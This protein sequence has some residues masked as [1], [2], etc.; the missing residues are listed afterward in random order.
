MVETRLLRSFV[1]VAE[2]L[3]FGRAARRLHIA[4]PALTRQIQQL[5]ERLQATLLNRNQRIV[6]LTPA[7][8][9]FLERSYRILADLEQ[10]AK[11]VRRVEA[12]QEGRLSVGFIHSSTYGVTPL[13]LRRFRL[14]FPRV[15]LELFEMTIQEQLAALRDGQIDVGILRPPISDPSLRARP[16][17][18]ERFV[19]ALPHDHRLA[20]TDRLH[21]R[22][23]SEDGF[24]LFTQRKSPL[25][26]ARIIGMCEKAGFVPRVEQYATQIHTMIGLVSAG[27]GAAIVPEVA[28]SLNIPGV[29]YVEIADTPP[30]V[31]VC[32]GWRATDTSPILAAFCDH[33]ETSA[34]L[35]AETAGG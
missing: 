30:T 2:E 4:Q 20:S 33:A 16:L 18:E 27:M 6:T 35:A 12:G 15:D 25:F 32:L 28:R 31:Q 8:R 24:I 3:H 19:V 14:A 5:E 9:M 21:L 22:D 1:C 7:G 23:L 29:A 26:Y 10:A 13:V 17:R 34:R 11:E